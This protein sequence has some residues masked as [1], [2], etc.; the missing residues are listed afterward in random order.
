MFTSTKFVFI[1][2]TYVKFKDRYTYFRFEKKNAFQF[3]INLV[4]DRNCNCFVSAI[5]FAS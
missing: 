2:F 1:L 5:K 4:F 3:K